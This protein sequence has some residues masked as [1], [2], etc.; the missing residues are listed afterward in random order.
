MRGG[1]RRARFNHEELTPI[2]PPQNTQDVL[3]ALGQVFSEVHGGRIEP[4]VANS[5][6]Y[7]ASG[8]LQALSVGDFEARIAALEAR[9]DALKKSGL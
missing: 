7:L 6:A 1:K 3:Q 9:S 5:L 8:I 4:R 2:A